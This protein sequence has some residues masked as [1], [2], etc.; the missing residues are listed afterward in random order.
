[1]LQTEVFAPTIFSQN[2]SLYT[3]QLA[4]LS[5]PTC[6]CVFL[7]RNL[8]LLSGMEVSKEDCRFVKFRLMLLVYIDLLLDPI[9][10][11]AR[12]PNVNQFKVISLA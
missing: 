10:K 1:M 12:I 5:Q 4:F 6:L 2:G 9:N 7:R 3:S 8:Y 11:S